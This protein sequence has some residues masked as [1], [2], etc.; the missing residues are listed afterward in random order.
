MSNYKFTNR[1]VHE[2]SPYLLQ[3]AH[4]PVE[5]FPWGEEAFRKA[6]EEDKPVFL[7][8][9]YSTCHWC[10]VMEHE[11]FEDEE[12]AQLMNDTFVSIKVD[13]EERP[14]ID[15]IY[16]TVCQMMTG[17]GGWPLSVVMTPDKKPFFSG[18]YF[19][20][21]DKYGR[22]GFK[23]LIKQIDDVW[24]T[25]KMDVFQSAEKITSHLLDFAKT[26]K[27][28]LPGEEAMTNAFNDFFKRFDKDNGGFGSAPKFPSA[29]NILFLLRYW[30]KS[31][32]QRALEMVE[33]TL[34]EMRMGGLFDHIGF[35]FHRYSTDDH[36]LLPHFEKML[37]DQA[38]LVMAYTEAYQATGKE[39]YKKTAEEVISYVLRDMTSENNAFFSA[40]DAD[41]DGEEG[42]FYVWSE[43]EIDHLLEAT[44]AKV[45]KKVFN[46]EHEGNFSD[47]SS[48]A[49]SGANILHIVKNYDEMALDFEMT[50]VEFRAKIDQLLQRLY[51][52]RETRV[53]PYKDDKILTDWNGLMIAALAKAGKTFGNEEYVEAAMRAFEFIDIDMQTADCKLYHRYRDEEAAI[54]ANLDDYAFIIWGLL[55][56]YEA[57]SEFEYL[58]K[59]YK[60]TNI[61]LD[62]FQD[63]KNGGFY[64]TPE[65]GE[66]TIVRKKELFDA[67]IPSGNS[68]MMLNL[69]R[70]SRITAKPEFEEF[71]LDIAKTASKFISN[72]PTAFTQLLCALDFVVGPSSEIIIA[73]DAKKAKAAMKKLD[74]EFSPN[75]V[76]I[77]VESEN[78]PVTRLA[79][80]LSSYKSEG[81]YTFYVCKNYQCSLPTGSVEEVITLLNSIR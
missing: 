12:I 48:R 47:E 77:Y 80:Y 72:S 59:A 66:T 62:E 53:K 22:V 27:G 35:G 63:K 6:F 31:G 14:D 8:I 76:I 26:E 71:A 24:K 15:N 3:H 41:S 40:E 42:K 9:G 4:N 30:K 79:D 19:P 33:K 37:Y 44:D 32:D 73:G 28:D 25:R 46:V 38:M 75:K 50:P 57:S 56:L 52:H 54:G 70:L 11:S 43:A 17:G 49:R 69:I 29:Q 1:L 65:T 23:N 36:W 7:S 74:K 78:A 21:E 51:D 20:K 60:F 68:V 18:T 55:E 64:F 61:V 67:A 45:I 2:K 58:D 34:A 16:M 5:W 13:R 10:H 81:D 39:F